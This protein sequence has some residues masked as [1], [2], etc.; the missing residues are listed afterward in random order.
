[1][2]IATFAKPETVICDFKKATAQ[3][4]HRLHQF[5]NN[6]VPK[7]FPFANPFHSF[8]EF[9][10][11]FFASGILL[12]NLFQKRIKKERKELKKISITPFQKH[13]F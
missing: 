10:A 1:M 11:I 2:K 13:R 9:F 7:P 8:P 6:I 4:I 12:Q 3:Q 5:E